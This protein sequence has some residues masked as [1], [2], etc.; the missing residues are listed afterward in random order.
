M[1]ELRQDGGSIPP[2]STIIASTDMLEDRKPKECSVK[3]C[4]EKPEAELQFPVR[5]EI[6]GK[7]TPFLNDYTYK[8]P[9]CPEHLGP[10]MKKLDKQKIDY[11][12]T[13]LV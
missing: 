11:G 7:E 8:E 13:S 4:T 5:F 6:D 1:V 2:G 9:L 12:F 10:V 3:G